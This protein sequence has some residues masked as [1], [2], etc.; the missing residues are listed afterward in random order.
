[1]SAVSPRL[2]LTST[3][4][5]ITADRRGAELAASL[6]RL[7]ATVT[8]GPTMRAVPPEQDELLEVETRAMLAAKPT[9]LAV[10]TGSG[11]RAWLQAAEGF[12]L[13]AELETFLGRTRTVARGSKSHGSLRGL[14][15]EPE[16]V[17][18][19]E[20]MDDVCSWLG[21]HIDPADVLGVQV[22]GGEVVGTLDALRPRLRAVVTV[23]PYRWVLPLDT[24]P[25]ERVVE[26]LVAGEV[27]VLAETSAPSVRNLFVIAKRMGAHA[28]LLRTLRGRVVVACVGPVTARAFE[29]VGVPVDL[30]PTRPRTADLLRSLVH[31]VE[32]GDPEG[33]EDRGPGAPQPLSAALEL[34]PGACAVRMG[35]TVVRLGRQEFAVLAALVR[36][37]GVVIGPDDLAVQAWG[38]RA[39]DDATKIRHYIARIRRKLMA[40]GERLQTVR[41][42]GYR[43]QPLPDPDA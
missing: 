10:S 2:P 20:T 35:P 11:L 32:A 40:Q 18:R 22:H 43:Y 24:G 21:E 15:V 7:G 29:E 36:R 19:K 30:M 14:G 16:F 34:V 3:R 8:W 41:S 4:V 9:W 38:H 37:P 28:D 5:A 39:P 31:R 26:R 1:M 42:V 6:E 25:A 23:A 27:D 17:S 33:P 13:R 12:E